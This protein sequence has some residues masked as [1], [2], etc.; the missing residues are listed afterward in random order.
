MESHRRL[1]DA[2]LVYREGSA[3]RAY[4]IPGRCEGEEEGFLLRGTG[5]AQIRSAYA[6]PAARGRGI[7]KALLQRAMAWASAHGCTRLMVEHE[8][9]NV[10]GGNFWRRHFTPYLYCSTRYVDCR[11]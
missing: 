9:A 5:T 2:L 10:L 1:G 3:P 8:T 4:F 7:G 6:P 11:L